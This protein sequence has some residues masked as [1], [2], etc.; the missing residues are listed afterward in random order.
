[1]PRSW[2]PL[3]VSMPAKP[4]PT[5]TTVVS[6]TTGSRVNPGSTHGS[7][8]NASYS[9]VSCEY[10]AWPSSRSRFSRSARYRSRA[11]LIGEPSSVMVRRILEHVLVFGQIASVGGHP[12]VDHQPVAGHEGRG[13]AG[14]EERRRHH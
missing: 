4:P 9:S 8:S 11:A 7:W 1:M 14:E 5:M 3:A 10:W 13:V 6:S 12:A 2:R